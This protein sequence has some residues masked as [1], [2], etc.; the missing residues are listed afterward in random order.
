ML[1][2]PQPAVEEEVESLTSLPEPEPVEPKQTAEPKK[3]EG[4]RLMFEIK[5]DDGFSITSDSIDGQKIY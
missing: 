3:A 5:S 2:C 4:P 1:S